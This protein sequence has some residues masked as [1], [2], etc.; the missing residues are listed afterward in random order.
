M[1]KH[2]SKA[3]IAL[4]IDMSGSMA[5]EEKANKIRSI[6]NVIIKNVNK[7]RDKLTVIGFKGKKS[8]IIIPTTKRPGSF[9]NK[10]DNISIGGTTPTAAGLAKGLEVLKN[11]KKKNEFVPMLIMLSDGMPNVAIKNSPVKDVLHIGEELKKNNI[12]T[13][14]IDFDRKYKYGHNINMD[15]AL[16]AGGRYYD[17]EGVSNQ[18]IVIDKI[19]NHER[20]NL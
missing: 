11:E 15:L 12:Y 20:E 8:E 9:H 17:L 18:T 4:I 19:L 16:A 5:S 7:N 2:K 14:V 3:S 1:R 13:T 10:L 6:I